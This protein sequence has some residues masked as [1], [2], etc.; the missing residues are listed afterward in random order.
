MCGTAAGTCLDFIQQQSHEVHGI[1]QSVGHALAKAQLAVT[2]DA[3]QIFGS[4][5]HARHFG[6]IKQARIA[7]EGVH[8]AEQMAHEL[9][10]A[11]RFLQFEQLFT[12]ALQ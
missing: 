4:M 12:D 6:K 8:R 1:E 7:L 10:V 5:Q 11:G 2:D 9:G 3:H